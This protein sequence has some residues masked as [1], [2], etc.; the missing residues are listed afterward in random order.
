MDGV[1]DRVLLHVR[2]Q[3]EVHAE[4]KELPQ[5]PDS[6][7][8]AE[9]HQ[10]QERRGQ[11]EGDP[12]IVVQ[13]HHHGEAYRRGQE[14]VDGVEHGVPSGDHHIKG[15]DL[16]QN[17]CRKD[18]AEN[19]DLQ[20]R[21]QLDPQLHLDPAGHVEQKKRENAEEGALV[22]GQHDLPHQH[23]QHQNP[24]DGKDDEGAF[25]FPQLPRHSLL[26]CLFILLLFFLCRLQWVTSFGR[27]GSS[28]I[29]RAPSCSARATSARERR[30][31]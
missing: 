23:H 13:Q 24:Q 2:A 30:V 17:F 14:A 9:G 20:G 4:F 18:E 6:H 7:G 29:G 16:T 5:D 12:V 25:V 10:G 15:V 19:G 21:R 8:E 27:S 26:K 28:K 11:M 1:D 22:V 3:E 31:Q